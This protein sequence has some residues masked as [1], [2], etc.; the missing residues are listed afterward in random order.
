MVYVPFT[1]VK[2][3][4]VLQMEPGVKYKAIWWNP[5]SGEERNL[6]EAQGDASGKWAAPGL[7]GKNDALL[8]LTK[9]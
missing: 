6:G 4:A 8:V 9:A 1:G 7:P 5:V 3:K 2:P